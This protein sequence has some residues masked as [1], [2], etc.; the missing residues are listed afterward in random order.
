M[1]GSALAWGLA[2]LPLLFLPA[3]RTPLAA[4]VLGLLLILIS[5]ALLPPPPGAESGPPGAVKGLPLKSSLSGATVSCAVFA[6]NS[7]GPLAGT[8]VASFPVILWTNLMVFHADLGQDALGRMARG[9]MVGLLGGMVFANAAA[10]LFPATGILTA[11]LAS[12]A[13]CMAAVA[14]IV[15]LGGRRDRR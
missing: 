3:V 8:V 15:L 6:A 11:F 14:V 2:M 1:A 9:F 12:Y 4:N 10:V 13:G 5:A 7:M